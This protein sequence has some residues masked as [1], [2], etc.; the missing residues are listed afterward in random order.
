MESGDRT[1]NIG[2]TITS[3]GALLLLGS[4]CTLS[5]AGSPSFINYGT[6]SSSATVNLGIPLTNYGNMTVDISPFYINYP[7]SSFEGNINGSGLLVVSV[8]TQFSTG[9]VIAGRILVQNSQTTLQVSGTITFA[10]G[11]ALEHY[12]GT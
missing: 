1:L 12:S 3:Y 6:I 4:S 9:L 11:G 7:G 8:T 2:A 5:S 10:S